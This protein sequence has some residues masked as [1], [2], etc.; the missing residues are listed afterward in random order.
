M[1]VYCCYLAWLDCTLFLMQGV[2]YV[3]AAA[4]TLPQ[5][6][7]AVPQANINLDCQPSPSLH[8]PTTRTPALWLLRFVGGA[9]TPY[10]ETGA[11]SERKVNMIP[12]ANDTTEGSE[13]RR[14]ADAFRE[15]VEQRF[16]GD[17]YAQGA[18]DPGEEEGKEEEQETTDA[19]GVAGQSTGQEPRGDYPAER[20]R[21]FIEQR[22]PEGL[23]ASS[24]PWD[25]EQEQPE[26]GEE[27]GVA[28][29]ST[30]QEP[31]GDYP[32]ERLRDFIEQRFPEGLPASSLPWDTDQ[33]QPEVEEDSEEAAE[34]AIG[35]AERGGKKGQA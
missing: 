33:E 13:D 21:D 3:F 1:D 32:A 2:A 6:I 17:V 28:E 29:Q 18:E 30:S 4:S 19:T 22:F 15:L 31:R 35:E 7:F 34:D 26:A 8:E 11:L 16:P 27:I 14:A 25:T 20:L 23:P 10:L 9:H 24:L 5:S 12:G